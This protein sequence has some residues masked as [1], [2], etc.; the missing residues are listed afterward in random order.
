[1]NVQEKK[2]ANVK[3]EDEHDYLNV[4]VMERRVGFRE[5]RRR[6]DRGLT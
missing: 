1:M 3:T 5:R 4:I 2:T 6:L